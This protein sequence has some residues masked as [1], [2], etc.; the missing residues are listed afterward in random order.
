MISAKVKNVDVDPRA[1]E[2][3]LKR[4]D[5]GLDDVAE[6]IFSRSQEL[7]AVDEGMLKKSGHVES[8]PLEKTLVYDAPYAEYVEYGTDPHMPPFEPIRAWVHRKRADLGVK[9]ADVDSVAKA[10]QIKIATYG[11]QPQPYLRPAFDEI[12]AQAAD[13]ISSHFNE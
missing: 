3:F 1:T 4:I 6:A 5:Q 7:V 8:E 12:E 2:D 13:I 10:I 11:T 9:P